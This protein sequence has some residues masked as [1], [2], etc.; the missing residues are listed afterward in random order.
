MKTSVSLGTMSAMKMQ[1]VSIRKARTRVHARPDSM[2]M[3][4]SAT[5]STSVLMAVTSAAIRPL[6]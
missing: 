2:A 3:V 4:V 1:L 6:A 5:R